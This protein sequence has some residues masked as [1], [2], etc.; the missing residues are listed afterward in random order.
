MKVADVM[1]TSVDTVSVDTSVKE[2]CRLIFGRG[3]NGIPVCKGKKVIGFISERD[4]LS[5][6]HPSIREYI[7]DPVH[8]GGF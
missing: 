4:I 5:R 8:E 7:E 3:I 1:S 6:F 2:V